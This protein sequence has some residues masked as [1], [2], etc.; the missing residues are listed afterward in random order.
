MM[1]G[2]FCTLDLA[3]VRSDVMPYMN[4]FWCASAKEVKT[5]RDF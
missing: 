5:D 3:N 4:P 2:A 1:K